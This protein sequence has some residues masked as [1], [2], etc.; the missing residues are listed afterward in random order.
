MTAAV[1]SWGCL[2]CFAIGSS[3]SGKPWGYY[4]DFAGSASMATGGT[5]ENLTGGSPGSTFTVMGGREQVLK[6]TEDQYSIVYRS[7]YYILRS[8]SSQAGFSLPI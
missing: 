8:H 6:I 7:I 3:P 5:F 2:L 1:A 4:G